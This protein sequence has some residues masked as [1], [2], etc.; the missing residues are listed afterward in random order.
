MRWNLVTPSLLVRGALQAVYWL[1]PPPFPATSSAKGSLDGWAYMATRIATP[2][3]PTEALR[4]YEGLVAKYV[5]GRRR[6]SGLPPRPRTRR[7]PALPG[8]KR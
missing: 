8:S 7:P 3:D 4:A 1:A 5:T 2:L 6:A